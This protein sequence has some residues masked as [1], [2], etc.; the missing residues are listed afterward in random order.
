MIP[1]SSLL[2]LAVSLGFSPLS[3]TRYVSMDNRQSGPDG[4]YY[5]LKNAPANFNHLIWRG[6]NECVFSHR[7]NHFKPFAVETLP[8]IRAG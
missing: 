2:V 3:P 5:P 6:A 4:H 8:A 1:G 7:D